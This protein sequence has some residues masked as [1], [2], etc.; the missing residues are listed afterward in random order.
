MNP[1]TIGSFFKFGLHHVLMGWDHL[2][3]ASA[4]VLALTG[5]WEVFKVVGIFTIAH[6]ITVTITALHGR[7]VDPKYV[8]PAIA[9]SIIFVAVEN[10]LR[11]DTG[12][13][14]RRLIVAFL[15]GL[16]HGL[17]FGGALV[18]NLRGL[19]GHTAAWAIGAFCLGVEAGHLCV[20]APLSGAL[21]IGRDL[22]GERF[23]FQTL[24]W[25]SVLIALAGCYYLYAAITSGG[26]E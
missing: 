26:A 14:R 19:P 7:L 10:I 3:F 15:F 23:R 9:A 11:K 16:V 20:V 17:G 18:G 13:N 5:F 8:E 22:G 25:G 2:L 12:L 6:S 4:L 21:K 1:D 24:R